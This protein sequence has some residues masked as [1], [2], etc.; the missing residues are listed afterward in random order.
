MTCIFLIRHGEV[1][2]NS[3]ERRTY[4]GWGDKPLTARGAAQARAVARRL[5]RERLQ[6]VYASD[7]Q[8]ARCTAEAIAVEQGLAAATDAAFRELSYGAWEGLSQD[9]IMERWPGVWQDRL[10]DLLQV[11]P[12]DGE[13]LSDLWARWQPAWRRIVRKHKDDT[14]ALVSHNAALRV[15]LCHLLGAPPQHY[16]RIHLS[17]CGLT[18]IEIKGFDTEAAQVLVGYIN[19][20]C[21]L[22][23]I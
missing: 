15:L 20:T 8:R 10:N 1:T 5:G 21:H 9:E 18:R 4:E 12:P 3:G 22:E 16:R 2:G 17:N 7:L 11:G 19:E 6:A 13:S 14:I 23:S